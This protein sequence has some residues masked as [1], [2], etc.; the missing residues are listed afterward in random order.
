MPLCAIKE[1][2]TAARNV[3]LFGFVQTHPEKMETKCGFC[4]DAAA[5][6]GGSGKGTPPVH[7]AV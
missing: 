3:Y 7:L 5:N 6:L 1:D 4:D 2:V